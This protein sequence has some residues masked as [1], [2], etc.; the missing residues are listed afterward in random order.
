MK[1]LLFLIAIAFTFASCSKQS[2][3]LA[4]DPGPN[5]ESK[6]EFKFDGSLKQYFT[7]S[8]GVA[9]VTGVNVYSFVGV[10]NPTNDNIFQLIFMTDSLRPGTYNVNTGI[11][12]FREVNTVATNI[13]ST[14][15]T[16]TITSNVNGLVNGSFKGTVFNQTASHNSTILEGL[17]QNI[18]LIY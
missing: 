18:Q 7:V 17:I 11:V 14:D 13:S 4:V 9:H 10:K 5:P 12:A 2:S 8:A 16:V 3:D 1:H 15:F 6:I